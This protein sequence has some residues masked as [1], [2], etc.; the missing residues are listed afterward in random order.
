MRRQAGE[1]GGRTDPVARER[2]LEG[3]VG[4]RRRKAS[5]PASAFDIP[6]SEKGKKIVLKAEDREDLSRD[7]LKVRTEPFRTK[8]YQSIHRVKPVGFRYQRSTRCY[9]LERSV[10]G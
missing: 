7:I 9:K 8:T 3:D 4:P 10:E 2:T 1:G 5:P 6:I